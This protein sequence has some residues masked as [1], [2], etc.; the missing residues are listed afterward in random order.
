VPTVAWS[1]LSDS[2]GTLLLDTS[3]APLVESVQSL[4]S[5]VINLVGGAV[6]VPWTQ[7]AALIIEGVVNEL[8]EHLFPAEGAEQLQQIED[9]TDD[10]AQRVI[11]IQAATAPVTSWL[12]VA[13]E[14]INDNIDGITVPPFELPVDYPPT[15]PTA[16][17]TEDIASDVWGF[18]VPMNYL[19]GNYWGP[20]TGT[21]LQAV[22][23]KMQIEGGFIGYPLVGNPYFTYCPIDIERGNGWIGGWDSMATGA[24]LPVLDLSLIAEGDTVLSYLNREY[25]GFAWT[26]TGPGGTGSGGVVW[27]VGQAGTF[28]WR[29]ILTDAQL[30]AVGGWHTEEVTVNVEVPTPPVIST[31]TTMQLGTPISFDAPFESAVNCH[32]VIID[33][34]HQGQGIKGYPVGSYYNIY[35]AGSISFLAIEGHAEEPQWLAYNHAIYIPKT[36]SEATGFLLRPR[37][38]LTGTVTPFSLVPVE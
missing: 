36:T 38:G 15:W 11:G 17:S 24:Q 6:A 26:L 30:A 14:A 16:P 27:L 31:A 22:A 35:G 1:R 7:I 34:S 3:S 37:I 32:G 33:C 5:Y 9:N 2:S 21:L 23:E 12:A 13:L 8:A 4:S 20:A 29:C 28:Y 10:I 18:T 25:G 19:D